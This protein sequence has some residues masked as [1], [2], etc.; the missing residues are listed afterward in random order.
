MNPTA[1][2]NDK[3]LYPGENHATLGVRPAPAVADWAA[4]RL[5]N[6]FRLF[7]ALTIAVVYYAAPSSTLGSRDPTLFEVA[8]LAW[9]VLGL[10]FTYLIRSRRPSVEMQLYLQSYLDVLCVVT[11]LY[12]SGGVDSG[13]AP[14]LVIGIAL[15]SQLVPTR[16]ALLFAAIASLV[17]LSEELLARFLHG[18][19]A[20]NLERTALLGSSLFVV[21]W[22]VTVPARRLSAR[23][24]TVPTSFRSSLDVQQVA[25]LNEEIVQELD[26]GVLVV[27]A[28]RRV[29]VIN[30]AARALLGAEFTPLPIALDALCP[31]LAQDLKQHRHVPTLGC[32]PLEIGR[33]GQTVL[34]SYTGLSNGGTLLR[35]DDHAQILQQFQQLKLAS[36]G[37]LSASI[38][39]EIR[40]PLGALSHA[41]Q[42][43]EEADALNA[44]DRELLSVAG[45]QTGRIDR[46]VNDVL[47]VS[48]RRPARP[49][50]IDL[51]EA[52]ESFRTRCLQQHGLAE[53]SIDCC[54]EAGMRVSFDPEQLDQ[55]LWNL[56]NNARLH[57]PTTDIAVR[58]AA[59]RTRHD[60]IVLDV[61]DNGEGIAGSAIDQLFEPFYSTSDAG[62]GLGLYIVRELCTANRATIVCEPCGHGAHFRLTL[63]GPEELA[64]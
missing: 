27:D 38:A 47:D 59:W 5:L 25:Q 37:R 13:L 11:I 51:A 46:I 33:V 63:N 36:L 17:V 1:G 18:A 49:A 9:F 34:P 56:C 26:S 20:A 16:Q 23:D 53:H 3:T 41:I 44:A 14:L 10:A 43:L 29:H 39:H 62:S 50:L 55:V 30:D 28:S 60:A 45:R 2:S 6:Q 64:A 7:V 58:I 31:H 57:N 4:L 8:H 21:A 52:V 42:L 12:A 48:N 15:L 40:N 54:V 24:V 32:R 19:D 61:I 35:L 22:L